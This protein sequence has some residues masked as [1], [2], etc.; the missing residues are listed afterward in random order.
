M[1]DDALAP[2]LESLDKR[3]A[4]LDAH[5]PFDPLLL[6][7]FRE[8]MAVE[9]TYHSNAIEGN[10]LNKQETHLILNEGITIG[11]KSMREHLEVTNHGSAMEHVRRLVDS[12][13]DFTEDAIRQLHGIVLRGIDD[14]WAGRYRC[15]DVFISGSDHE[16]PQWA[17]VPRLMQ[18]LGQ[19]L[20][21]L[22]SQV[23]HP[24][25]RA[26]RAH[27]RVVHIHPF[28]DGNGRTA[29]L[30]MNLLLMQRGYPI[31]VIRVEDRKEYFGALETG[32]VNG[33]LIPFTHFIAEQ[34]S[35]SM[36]LYLRALA[37]SEGLPEEAPQ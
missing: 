30:A 26:A 1:S 11:G 21:S 9:W 27:S 25:L 5:R 24:V 15:E 3:K 22:E 2:L 16:P 4:L 36:N 8:Y 13:A 17:V 31:A 10:T 35:R 34:V 32:H 19:W 6:E 23:L 14:E 28:R 7:R 18:E 20:A 37:N 29:R 12:E 33:D